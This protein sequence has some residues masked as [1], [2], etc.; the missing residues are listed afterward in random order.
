MRLP[1]SI[2]KGNFEDLGDYPT[3]LGINEE[4]ED[5]TIK[6]KFCMIHLPF[7]YYYKFGNGFNKYLTEEERWN[8]EELHFNQSNVTRILELINKEKTKLAGE[9][10]LPHINE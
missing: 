7:D 9:G 4:F 8:S 1:R 6:G 3:C 10:L 2:L 5:M